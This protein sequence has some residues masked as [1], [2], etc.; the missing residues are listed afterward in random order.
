MKGSRRKEAERGKS[1]RTWRRSR[2]FF[3]FYEATRSD[4]TVKEFS[5]QGERALLCDSTRGSQ[6]PSS[7]R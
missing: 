6:A 1:P 7:R 3:R 4:E 2:G 5:Q